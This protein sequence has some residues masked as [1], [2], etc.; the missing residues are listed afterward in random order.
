MEIV[1]IEAYL[2]DYAPFSEKAMLVIGP[3]CPG[4]FAT[5]ILSFKSHTLIIESS[6]P[7]PKIKPSGWNWAHVRAETHII[8]TVQSRDLFLFISWFGETLFSPKVQLHHWLCN[9]YIYFKFPCVLNWIN[10]LT[11][12]WRSIMLYKC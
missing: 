5:L 11:E 12:K 9:D 6:V 7:V 10:Y 4:K 3:W 1:T 8:Y 2:C